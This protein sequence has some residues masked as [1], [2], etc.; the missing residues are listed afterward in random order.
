MCPNYTANWKIDSGGQSVHQH[1]SAWILCT[2]SED[3]PSQIN[4]SQQRTCY[5]KKQGMQADK[6]NETNHCCKAFG[7]VWIWK[8]VS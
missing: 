5:K 8:L 4:V 7:E 6:I 2:G 3:A 1:L